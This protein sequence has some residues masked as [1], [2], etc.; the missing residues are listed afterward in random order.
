VH[1]IVLR[2]KIMFIYLSSLVFSQVYRPEGGPEGSIEVGASLD[3]SISTEGI[4]SEEDAMVGIPVV[5]LL[6]RAMFIRTLPGCLLGS[7]LEP[8]ENH[9]YASKRT[10]QAATNRNT[11]LYSS[12]RSL[13]ESNVLVTFS[14]VASIYFYTRKQT[15]F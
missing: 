11:I 14:T 1:F 3:C 2:V 15:Y 13:N 10:R 8:L 5:A 9:R 12:K 6:T 7:A 4:G